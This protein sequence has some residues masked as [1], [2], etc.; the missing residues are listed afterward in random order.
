M[1]RENRN[2]NLPLLVV[3][4][5]ALVLSGCLERSVFPSVKEIIEVERTIDLD[6]DGIPDQ[7]IFVFEEIQVENVRVRREIVSTRAVGNI[8]TIRLNIITNVTDKISEVRI[9]EVIPPSLATS[10]DKINFT[11]K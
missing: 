5:F 4:L 1:K 2:H 9:Q 7:T 10:L 11:T 3:L 8:V 6:N